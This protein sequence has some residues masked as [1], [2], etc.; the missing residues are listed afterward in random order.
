MRKYFVAAAALVL[1]ASP[2]RSDEALAAKMKTAGLIVGGLYSCGS[3][4][5]AKRITVDMG[6]ES[7]AKTKSKEEY[8]AARAAFL[9]NLKS[10]MRPREQMTK[11]TCDKVKKLADNAGY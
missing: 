9:T 8:Q 10:A 7:R 2:V 3:T 1:L 11:E 5:R 6:K 4:D